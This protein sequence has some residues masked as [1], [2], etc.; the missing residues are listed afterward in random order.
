M[1]RRHTIAIG[2]FSMGDRTLAI[3]T[4]GGDNSQIIVSAVPN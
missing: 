3:S 4:F 1:P 2:S